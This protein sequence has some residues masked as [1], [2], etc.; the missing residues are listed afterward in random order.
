MSYRLIIA[1]LGLLMFIAS[2]ADDNQ[3]NAVSRASAAGAGAL[4]ESES[5]GHAPA[6]G[7]EWF[8]APLCSM[9]ELEDARIEAL[10]A[11]IAPEA[12]PMQ[13]PHYR[14]PVKPPD[15]KPGWQGGG[16]PGTARRAVPPHVLAALEEYKARAPG[17]SPDHAARLKAELL[18][19][20]P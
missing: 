18:G 8:G 17:M 12:P 9:D 20:S 11:M 7:D 10:E 19:E 2:C 5:G 14:V 16:P 1:V 3:Q 4:T 6:D 13:N 15:M